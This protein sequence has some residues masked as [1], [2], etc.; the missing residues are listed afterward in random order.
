MTQAPDYLAQDEEARR[1]VC[2][3]LGETLFVEAGAGTGK[4]RA[5]V[6]RI[7]ALVCSGVPIDQIAAITFTERA[8]AE[9]RER[10]RTGLEE[11]APKQ[12]QKAD[13]INARA[14][15][16]GSR[17]DID[18]PRVLPGNRADV[19]AGGRCRS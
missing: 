14:R 1:V 6:D 9:L 7:V 17:A 12:S 15:L 2:E 19:R 13:V 5:L 11:E 10:V 8:A 18:D 4:T 16:V 3:A